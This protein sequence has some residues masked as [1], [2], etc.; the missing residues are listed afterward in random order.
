MVQKPWYVKKP[1]SYVKIIRSIVFLSAIAKKN[2][3]GV[4]VTSLSE[5][6]IASSVKENA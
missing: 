6:K 3:T 2:R 1:F 5:K 4:L